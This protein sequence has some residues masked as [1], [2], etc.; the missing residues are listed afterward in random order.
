MP[1]SKKAAILNA[2]EELFALHGLNGASMRNIASQAKVDVSLITYHFKTK[3]KLFASVIE[4][5]TSVFIREQ[6]FYFE[7]CERRASPNAPSV[8]DVVDAYCYVFLK[9][10]IAGD[11]HWRNFFHL[12]TRLSNDPGRGAE[13]MAQYFDPIAMRTIAALQMALPDCD[14][15]DIQWG[16]QF[17]SG[18]LSTCLVNTGS[19]NRLSKGSVDSDDY[20][21]IHQ[22]L[23]PFV[24]AGLQELSNKISD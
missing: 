17:L 3:D 6:L 7:E 16:F 8:E 18:A 1:L 10:A 24:C 14:P 11:H 23:V 19:V 22:S 9:R 13:I 4:R 15:K 12:F 5:R 20:K 2:A 21:K